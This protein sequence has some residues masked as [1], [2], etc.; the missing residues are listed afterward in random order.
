MVSVVV[1]VEG[2]ANAAPL[3]GDRH[4]GSAGVELDVDL[5]VAGSD[6]SS[7]LGEAGGTRQRTMASFE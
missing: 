2:V 4:A 5:G 1:V 3:A 7:A 6:F